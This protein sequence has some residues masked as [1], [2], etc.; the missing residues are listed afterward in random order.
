MLV[1]LIR[2]GETESLGKILAGRL[3]GVHLSEKGHHQ[4]STLAGTLATAPITHIF[5]SPLERAFETARPLAQKLNLKIEI[6]DAFNELEF[7]DWTGR[8]FAEL[9]MEQRWKQ[10]N[11]SRSTSRPPG[12]ETMLEAQQRF[13]SG[14]QKLQEEFPPA[15]IAIFSHADPIKSAIM[16]F[17]GMSLDLFAR[18]E[19]SPASISALSL[20]EWGAQI[21]AL[22]SVAHKQ[23]SNFCL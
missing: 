15:R 21:Y 16:H 1:F 2:H 8:S 3:P 9:D 12:G 17:L 5:S 13:V 11:L 20:H 22:N 23:L 18:F 10:W 4:A 14:L 7:G 6:Q 19:I